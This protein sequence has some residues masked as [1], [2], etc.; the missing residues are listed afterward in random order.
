MSARWERPD[1]GRDDWVFRV[2]TPTGTRPPW[3]M[4][5]RKVHRA[6][7]V[8]FALAIGLPLL[9]WGLVTLGVLPR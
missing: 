3:Y 1:P 7:A 5:D 6:F 4:D 8:Y 2:R 9:A